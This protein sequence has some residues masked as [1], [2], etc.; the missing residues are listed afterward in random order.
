MN[1]SWSQPYA[2][3]KNR[4]VAIVPTFEK[5]PNQFPAILGTG[6]VAST[7]G[8]VCTCKHVADAI[9]DLPRPT[10]YAGYPARAM[11]FIETVYGDKRDWAFLLLEILGIGYAT[12]FGDTSGYLGPNPPDVAFLLLEATETPALEV[13][14]DRLQEGEELAFAGFPMGRELLQAPGWLHQVSPTLHTGIAASILP[15]NH[16]R[17]PHSFLMHANTQGGGS[18]S[19]V[20]RKD[21]KVVGMVYLGIRDRYHFG[22]GENDNGATVYNV[23]TSLTCC[24]SREILSAVLPQVAQQATAEKGRKSLREFIANEPRTIVPGQ[25]IF[26]TWPP[27]KKGST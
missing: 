14:G 15:H 3:V 4:I 24:V 19:P 13:S 11:M 18:G 17:T 10:G 6:F 23:P 8:V 27:S 21:G 7:E 20:F 16:V 22:G 9:N 12:V 2:D 5:E 26:D 25:N 1:M